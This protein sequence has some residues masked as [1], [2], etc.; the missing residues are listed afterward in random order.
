L[1]LEVILARI[2]AFL[3]DMKPRKSIENTADVQSHFKDLERSGCIKLDFFANQLEDLEEK[4]KKAFDLYSDDNPKIVGL[5]IKHPFLFSDVPGKLLKNP[6]M[7]KLLQSYLG[8]DATF[9]WCQLHRIP[10]SADYQTLSGF[11]HHD[12]CGRRLKIFIYL[13]DVKPGGRVTYYAGGSHKRQHFGWSHHLN[14]KSTKTDQG[15]HS[16]YNVKELYGKKGQA[17]LFDS[18][19]FHRATWHKSN[20]FRDILSFE[21]SSHSK[22]K[23]LRKLGYNIGVCR[24]FFKLDYDIKGT[25]IH[26]DHI[27]KEGNYNAYGTSAPSYTWVYDPMKPRNKGEK[28]R[29]WE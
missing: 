23:I 8:E 27:R 10:V 29:V 19:G 22:S 21:F 1:R 28:A 12:R 15:M 13:H 25:L 4:V 9:D 5:N 24:E 7:N 11:W 2:S 6:K 20:Q 26:A 18:N 3:F 14:S 17:Y 16:K